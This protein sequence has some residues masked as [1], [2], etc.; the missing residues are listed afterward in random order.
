VRE[1]RFLMLIG[2]H[3]GALVADYKSSVFILQTFYNVMITL[4]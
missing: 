1:T 2:L 4:S 3:L